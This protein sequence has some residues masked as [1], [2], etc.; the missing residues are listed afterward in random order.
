MSSSKPEVFPLVLVIAQL[1]LK[2]AVCDTVE[3]AIRNSLRLLN[4]GVSTP[5]AF[6]GLI[7]MS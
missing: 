5:G 6:N 2:D 3:K 7:F 1:R 4:G